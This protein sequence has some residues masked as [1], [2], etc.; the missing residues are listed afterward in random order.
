[1]RTQLKTAR[2]TTLP[3]Y[4]K[5][6][7][8]AILLSSSLHVLAADVQLDIP[9]QPLDKALNTL[10]KQSGERIIFSTGLT[11]K[12][13]A[14][15]I[16][17]VFNARQALQK[18]LA[19]SGLV[20]QETGDKGFTVIKEPVTNVAPEV[21][22]EVTVT[23]VEEH[24]NAWGHLNGKVAKRSSTGTKTDTPIIET[25]QSISV[26]TRDEMDERNVRDIGD[27]VAYISGVTTGSTG[28]TT[29]FGGNNIRVRGF[30]GNGT[31][32]A[33][34][35][36]Y[37]DGLKLQSSDYV[38]ANLDP[39][40]FERIE[41]LKGPASVLFGQ[42][43]P[44][45]IVNMISKRPNAD[46]VNKIRIG[47][48]NFDGASAAFDI[49]G[50]LNEGLLFRIAG[51]GLDGDTQQDYSDRKRQLLAPSLRWANETTDITIL[52]NYQR[53]DINASI[54]SVVPRAGVFSNPN[55]RVP[56]NFRVGDPGFEFWDRESWSLGYL[57]SH[58][59]N[60]AL[61]FRQN[62]RFTNNKQDSRWIYRSTIAA[63]QRTLNRSTFK[64]EED[65]D[66]LAID[67][68]L[69]WKFTTGSIKHSLLTGV[70]YQ[71]FSDNARS[72]GGIAPSIDLFSPVYN[73]AISDPKTVFWDDADKIRQLGFY[74]QDQVKIGDLS[75]QFGGRYDKAEVSVE[76]KISTITTKKS[77]H[78]FTGR[79]GAI[80]NFNN[81]LAPYASYSE[82]FEPVRGAAFGGS[83]FEPMK[84]KQH[85]IGVKYQPSGTD[86]LYTVAAFDLTQENMTTRDPNNT[87]FSIQTGEVNTRGLEF[88][89][90]VSL[91]ENL[92]ITAAYTYLDDEVTKSNNVD[93]GNRRVQIPQHSASLWANYSIASGA[94]SGMDIGFGVRYMGETQGDIGNTFSVPN[95]V[96][97]DLALH[98]D[99]KKS[100]LALSGW[101]AN[102]N[103]NNVFDKYY[104]ASCFAVHSC[105]LGQERTFRASMEYNW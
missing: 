45:G 2:S 30:G 23:G 72:A 96:L 92:D 89:A 77:D 90:K 42:T 50:E 56:L 55:G 15:A 16:K 100:P 103:V 1:M 67:N 35:N 75:L 61:T 69:E 82:S 76:N 60:D 53:D 40:L 41:V 11:E 12:I 78:E 8:L 32:G 73:V 24:E 48:G 59:F 17:G 33:S 104:I 84:G 102:L 97:G 85:E 27:A 54:L 68:Q 105:Y 20:L 13:S 64:S 70:D 87:G 101:K 63:N 58:R 43:Q 88:E 14:P 66:N 29:L 19:G 62:L 47:T 31:A 25:P 10:A 9:A 94:L 79:V 65:S 4:F 49:G 71:K 34:F 5:C 51:L 26:I 95:Y 36:E 38:S 93:L 80:Y 99:L 57:F 81:G 52:A 86:N 39:W 18:L 46:M 91:N 44:G 28:E 6:T 7:A 3:Y 83:Q 22:S 21:L 74:L 37:M 98:Y